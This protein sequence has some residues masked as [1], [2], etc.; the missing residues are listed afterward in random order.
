MSQ[1]LPG[2][3][4]GEPETAEQLAE[5]LFQPAAEDGGEYRLSG[6]PKAKRR[7]PRRK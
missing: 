5:P 3:I 1:L 4:P 6:K 2:T 7:G